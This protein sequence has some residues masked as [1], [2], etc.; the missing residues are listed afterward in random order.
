MR[1][2][3]RMGFT[4]QWIKGIKKV[5]SLR[6]YVIL[7]NP[8]IAYVVFSSVHGHSYIPS[9]LLLLDL[10]WRLK[11]LFWLFLCWYRCGFVG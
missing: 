10:F 9:G 8:E 1:R 4:T 2:D 11:A 6:N 3:T 7:F 5:Q